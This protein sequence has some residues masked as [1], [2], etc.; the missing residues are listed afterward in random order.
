MT[1]LHIDPPLRAVQNAYPFPIA[2]TL[3]TAVFEATTAQER[4]EGLV[5]L[6]NTTL[7]YAALVVASN[8]AIAPFKEATTSYRLER[9]K[10]PLLSDFAH[11]LRVGVP[12][13]H[14]QGLLFIPELVTVL[15]ETQ[16]DRARALRMGEQGWEER[17][18]S[19]LEALLSLR[20]A[21]AHDRFR[22][23]WDAFVT[24]HTPLVSR[25]LHLMRW[26]ARYPLLRVVDAEHWVRLMGAHPAFVAEPIP[27]SA[28]ET[29]SCVQDSGEHTGLF[30]ADPLSSRL[31]PL[32]PF[33]LWA[34]C[35]YCVQDPLLGLHEEV[36]LF[37]GDEGRRYIAYIGVRHPRPLSH[38][39]AH[40]EQLYLD[41]SLPSP[42]LAVSHLSYGTLADRAGEQSDTWLQQ[43][44]AARRYLPPVYAPRQE[45]EAALTRFLRSRKGGFLLLGEAG[46]GK[47]NLLCHQV[48]EWT[49]QG[50]IVFCYAG[51]QLAT[52]T[53]LEEQIMRDL[54]LTGDFL[55][56]L[57]FLHREGRRLILVVDGVNEHENAPALLKHLCTFISRYT[58]REQG[59]A[60]GALKVI[61]SFRSSSFQKALQVLLAGGGE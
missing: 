17:E 53:G 19:L 1:S 45:M 6:V 48:E 23:T 49:R 35:P 25:F 7:Q 37:N 58:P 39:K 26:C 10:R 24:H 43:N 15:K 3:Q 56:L 51:H 8:Y 44:I 9:L 28:R 36:F 22:G 21:L 12:A 20:N 54:H 33:I 18:M 55:E 16:R 46:I 27:D 29:L 30:L 47:T 32:Y 13:L 31:L 40:I 14:E 61:L 11:F 5:R 59:E 34:D 2:F 38:P 60:R 52:D 4:V 42:P 41:K 57:P 50:E